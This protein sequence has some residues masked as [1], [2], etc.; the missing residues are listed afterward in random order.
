[1][2]Q[3]SALFPT[4]N[5]WIAYKGIKTL[6]G[7]NIDADGGASKVKFEADAEGSCKKCI[8]VLDIEN[9]IHPGYEK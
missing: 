3:I 2:L 1:M 4:S 6:C 8:V 5:P 7:R 9:R